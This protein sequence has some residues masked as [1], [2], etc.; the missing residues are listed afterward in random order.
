M[1]H[2]RRLADGGSVTGVRH[3]EAPGPNDRSW[4][5]AILTVSEPGRRNRRTVDSIVLVWAAIVIG[6]SAAI[7]S[8]AQGRDADVADALVTLLGWAGAIWRLAF[9]GVMA[10][11]LV[12]VI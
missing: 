10:L 2:G 7:G 6:L 12:I 8:S 4:S 9:L 11:V 5:I 3:G 1:A